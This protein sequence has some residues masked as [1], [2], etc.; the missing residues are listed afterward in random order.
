MVIVSSR[1]GHIEGDE[2]LRRFADELTVQ[3][4]TEESNDEY[5]Q[6]ERDEGKRMLVPRGNIIERRRSGCAGEKVEDGLQ[7]IWDVW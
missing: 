3:E 7:V 5:H 6:C 1:C 2:R 4:Q